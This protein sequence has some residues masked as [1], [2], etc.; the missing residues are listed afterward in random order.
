M[1]SNWAD[2]IAIGALAVAA[3]ILISVIRLG[4][5]LGGWA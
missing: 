1:Q 5:K 2:K 3:V 4:I